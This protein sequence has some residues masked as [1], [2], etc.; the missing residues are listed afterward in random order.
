MSKFD[1]SRM[2]WQN[3]V[4][5]PVN[6]VVYVIVISSLLSFISVCVQADGIRGS[7]QGRIAFAKEYT[8]CDSAF[9]NPCGPLHDCLQNEDGAY[10]RSNVEYIS[11]HSFACLL[12]TDVA[13]C[14]VMCGEGSTCVRDVLSLQISC[15]CNYGY[16]KRDPYFDCEMMESY[17]LLKNPKEQKE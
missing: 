15:Q 8:T 6:W 10:D 3:P 2:L 12:R 9:G 7:M 5:L 4:K 13:L 1:C 14:D 11:Q 17:K 16:Y